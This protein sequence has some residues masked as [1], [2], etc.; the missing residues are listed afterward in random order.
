MTSGILATLVPLWP[1]DWE[2]TPREKGK[3]RVVVYTTVIARLHAGL[4]P[5]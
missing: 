5:L 2:L 3:S 4:A 1:R